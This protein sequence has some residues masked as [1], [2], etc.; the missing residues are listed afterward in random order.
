[1]KSNLG[2][3]PYHFL[4]TTQGFD[5][6]RNREI[7]SRAGA[8]QEQLADLDLRIL[9]DSS[10]IEWKELGEKGSP[11]N[12]NEWEDQKVARRKKIL[13]RRIVL[14]K[15]FLRTNIEPEWMVDIL[16]ESY[17]SSKSYG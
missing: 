11:D 14:A 4:F 2:N 1:M 6:F 5:I 12:E 17:C 10:L 15:H 7:S 16:V 3:M 8:I 13:V 9:M